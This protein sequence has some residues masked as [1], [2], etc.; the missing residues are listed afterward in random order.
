MSEK[1]EERILVAEYILM[2]VY[3]SIVLQIQMGNISLD[4]DLQDKS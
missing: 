3:I 4:K 1:H 2:I